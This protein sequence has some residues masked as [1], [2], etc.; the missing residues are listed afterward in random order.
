VSANRKP[1]KICSWIFIGFFSSFEIFPLTNPK[2]EHNKAEKQTYKV[3]V[4]K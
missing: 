3:G 2:I 1:K 4:L